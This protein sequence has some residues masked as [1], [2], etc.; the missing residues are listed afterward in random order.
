[1]KKSKFLQYRNKK[2]W[3]ILSLLLRK[4]RSPLI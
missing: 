1:M 4:H 2:F 3:R